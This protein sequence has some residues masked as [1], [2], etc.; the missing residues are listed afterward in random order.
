MQKQFLGYKK[1]ARDGEENESIRN[2]KPCLLQSVKRREN[3]WDKAR[4]HPSCHH[5]PSQWHTSCNQVP[6]SQIL[7]ASPNRSTICSNPMGSIS[8][9][10]YDTGRHWKT[11]LL[12]TTSRCGWHCE[13]S[14]SNSLQW[15][16][17][18]V[19]NVSRGQKLVF[20]LSFKGCD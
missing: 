18:M 1:K 8:P 17:S 19:Q 15:L 4:T 12:T 10:S 13:P 2:G 20:K 16:Q 9:W 5:S 11:E 14:L 6:C 7:V 3:R